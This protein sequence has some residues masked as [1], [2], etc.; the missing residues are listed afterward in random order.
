MCSLKSLLVYYSS[1]VTAR[2]S[3]TQIS[4]HNYYCNL[5]IGL[6]VCTKARQIQAD[7]DNLAEPGSNA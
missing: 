4:R 7:I 2:Q 6:C 3:L 5:V 1:Q